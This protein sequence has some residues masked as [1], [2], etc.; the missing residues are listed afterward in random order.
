[1]ALPWG[2]MPWLAVGLPAC[3]RARSGNNK[4]YRKRSR[5]EPEMRDYNMCGNMG[6]R[7]RMFKRQLFLGMAY[8]GWQLDC[9]PVSGPGS[10]TA[11]IIKN[12]HE[13]SWKWG[14]IICAAI[15]DI[16]HGCSKGGSFLGWHTMDGSWT[17]SLCPGPVREQQKL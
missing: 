15:W 12:G 2:G 14:I 3:V 8:H 5:I 11:K 16:E 4:N 1:M 7:T 10:G 6:H 9:Q 13:L 17:A